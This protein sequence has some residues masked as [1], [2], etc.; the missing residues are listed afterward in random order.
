MLDS[1]SVPIDENDIFVGRVVEG[2]L[3]SYEGIP[4]TIYEAHILGVPVLATNV[5]GI[6]TQVTPGVNGWLVESDDLAI[7]GGI[8]H[9]LTHPEEIGNYK[10]N[11]EGYVYDNETIMSK[12]KE[13]FF[14]DLK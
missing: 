11:L 7:Y 4:N 3:D 1:V 8:K 12:T 2:T 9:V 13:M 5:G 14:G 6:A 10:K